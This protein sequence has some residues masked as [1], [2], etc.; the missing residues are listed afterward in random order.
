M[1]GVYTE[2]RRDDWKRF[3]RKRICYDKAW[4]S[5]QQSKLLKYLGEMKIIRNNIEK[6]EEKSNKK[7]KKIGIVA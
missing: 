4:Y 5:L 2:K 6:N 1:G 7:E 3:K